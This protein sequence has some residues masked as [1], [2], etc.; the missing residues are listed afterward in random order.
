MRSWGPVT[1]GAL[2]RLLEELGLAK[3]HAQRTERGYRLAPVYVRLGARGR[4]SVK[5]SWTREAPR[6]GAGRSAR[7]IEDTFAWDLSVGEYI[8]ASEGLERLY[9]RGH[10]RAARAGPARQLSV[11]YRS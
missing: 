10:G 6:P 9:G 5:L 1:E 4:M 11:E 3:V 7:E 2:A 8:K